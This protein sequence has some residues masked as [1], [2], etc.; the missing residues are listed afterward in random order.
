MTFENLKFLF[1]F[2]LNTPHGSRVT[3]VY[4]FLENRNMHFWYWDVPHNVKLYRDIERSS[5]FCKNFFKLLFCCPTANFGSLSRGQPHSPDVSQCVLNFWPEGHWEPRN[6]VGS[7]N[8]AERLAE[9]E[10]GTF[11]FLL[12]HL[13]PTTLSLFAPLISFYTPWKHQKTRLSTKTKYNFRF[14]K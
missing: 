8:L 1:L 3:E 6:E 11:R 5:N 12:P 14:Y 13:L 7:L 10:L 9:F 4:L 2:E